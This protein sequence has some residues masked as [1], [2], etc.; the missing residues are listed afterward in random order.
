MNGKQFQIRAA[1]A[2][3]ALVLAGCSGGDELPAPVTGTLISGVGV[4]GPV[5][6]ASV[7]VF[8]V[9]PDG[10]DGDKLGSGT[11]SSDGKFSVTASPPPKGPVRIR[12]RGGSY[13]SEANTSTTRTKTSLDALVPTDGKDVSGTAVTP[14]TSLAD[15]YASTLLKKSGSAADADSK[16]RDANKKIKDLFNLKSDESTTPLHKLVPDFKATSGD[17]A[18]A[19]LVLGTF[20]QLADNLKKDPSEVVHA[21]AEDLSDGVPDGKKDDGTTPTY[22]GSAPAPASLGTGDFLS[23]LS[24]YVDPNNPNTTALKEN[25]TTLDPSVTEDV[26][27]GVVAAAPPSSGLN[28][29]SSGAVATLSYLGKQVVFIAARQRGIKAVDITNPA[30]PVVNLLTSLNTALQ[31]LTPAFGD[32]GGVIAAPGAATPQVVLFSYSSPRVVLADVDAQRILADTNLSSILTTFVSFSGGSAYISGGIPDPA[33]G[34]VWLSTGDGYVPYDI[35]SHEAKTAMIIPLANSQ[36]N[37]ENIGGDVSANLLFSPNYGPTSSQNGGLQIVDLV[38][39]KAYSMDDTQFQSAFSYT[40]NYGSGP[41]SQ[42]FSIVDAGAVDSA[43]KVG[44]LTPEDS[45]YIGFIKLGDR[46]KIVTNDTTSTFTLS[47]TSLTKV[48]SASTGYSPT[49]SGAAIE[50]TNHLALFMAGYSSSIM[51]GKLDD[52][53]GASWAGLSDW[54]YY[55]ANGSSEYVYSRDPH[56]VGVALADADQRSYG[57][58]LSDDG[59]ALM[60]DM[61]RFLAAASGSTADTAHQLTTTPFDG[62]IV[63]RLDLNGTM[64]AQRAGAASKAMMK[65]RRYGTTSRR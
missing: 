25:G 1:I 52:P 42:P 31:A 11:T 26:R 14:L 54:R 41:V 3:G 13:H 28:A 62:T 12:I 48:L 57:F 50:S 4:A 56:A 22:D 5:D 33:R 43:Y 49:L 46:S 64:S 24:T 21:L 17:G 65:Q 16:I 29:G 34:V 63:R 44:V 19:A 30:A 61:Q 20:E 15:S 6:S 27:G 7:D 60:V 8:A 39:S 37:A 51:V 23:A 35:A 55:D 58:L 38:K 45:N 9:K 59:F 10:S 40:R 2:V 53:S 32:V 18:R 47:D 36:M